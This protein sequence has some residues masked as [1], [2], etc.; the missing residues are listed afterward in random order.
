MRNSVRQVEQWANRTGLSQEYNS[1]E[2]CL[3][4]ILKLLSTNSDELVKVCFSHLFT[5]LFVYLFV[6][7]LICLLFIRVLLL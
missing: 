4:S 6:Y 3:E 1:P 7:L 2:S 5:C